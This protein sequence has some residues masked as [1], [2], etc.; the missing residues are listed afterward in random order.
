MINENELKLLISILNQ[1]DK[2]GLDTFQ[3]L[4]NKVNIGDID[5]EFILKLAEQRSLQTNRNDINKLLEQQDDDRKQLISNVLN[6]L[7]SRKLTLAKSI[8]LLSEKNINIPKITKK[9]EL[10][11]SLVN[12]LTK[13]DSRSL[14]NLTSSIN[15]TVEKSLPDDPKRSL[16]AWSNVIMKKR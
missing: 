15:D 9:S 8:S 16:E 12:E 7:Q 10:Y 11:V 6:T 3:S 5:L 2:F 1:V 4:C 14:F 13:L